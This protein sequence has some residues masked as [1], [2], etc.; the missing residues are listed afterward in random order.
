MKINEKLI[1]DYEFSEEERRGEYFRKWYVARVLTRGGMEDIR[2][3]GL[4]VLHDYLPSLF[5]PKK[6]L[7]FWNWFFSLP[8]IKRQYGDFNPPPETFHS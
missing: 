6:I 4:Q 3:V 2:E 8:E 5:L 1:W 7:N